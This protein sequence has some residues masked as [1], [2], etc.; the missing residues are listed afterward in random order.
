MSPAGQTA[1][2]LLQG[3]LLS[4]GQFFPLH[5]IPVL[6]HF[7]PYLT[8]AE[9]VCAGWDMPLLQHV[10]VRYSLPFLASLD[11]HQAVEMINSSQHCVWPLPFC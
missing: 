10:P 8:L 4:N 9:E 6:P 1:P 2:F 3:E 11:V 5:S 7:P